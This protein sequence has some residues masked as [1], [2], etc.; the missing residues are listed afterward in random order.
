MYV[1]SLALCGVT[2]GLKFEARRVLRR[3]RAERCG[4]LRARGTTTPS[5]TS[6]AGRAPR[7]CVNNNTLTYCYNIVKLYKA[8]SPFL[9]LR[10]KQ[11]RPTRRNL[12]NLVL[13]IGRTEL[14]YQDGKQRLPR[15]RQS[16]PAG[17]GTAACCYQT[18]MLLPS[19]H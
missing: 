17:P 7:V 19:G 6:R 14:S 18:S 4:A 5:P 8:V 16:H 12:Q 1:I 11:P 3:A 9:V 15:G 10:K 13:L 2:D